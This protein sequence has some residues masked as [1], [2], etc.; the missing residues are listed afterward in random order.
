MFTRRFRRFA[1]IAAGVTFAVWPLCPESHHEAPADVHEHLPH[2]ESNVPA[3]RSAI[4][5]K[6]ST[7][8]TSH[9]AYPGLRR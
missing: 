9:A 3:F 8:F 2:Q 1:P 4:E 6:S 7:S 5:L